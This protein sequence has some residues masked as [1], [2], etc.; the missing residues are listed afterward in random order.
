MQHYPIYMLGFLQVTRAQAKIFPQEI[1]NLFP[2]NKTL[3]VY[4]RPGGDE[5]EKYLRVKFLRA[6]PYRSVRFGYKRMIK[7]ELDA[8]PLKACIYEWGDDGM[9]ELLFDALLYIHQELRKKHELKHKPIDYKFQHLKSDVVPE[10]Q[11]H[12]Y[13]TGLVTHIPTGRLMAKSKL[14]DSYIKNEIL[15]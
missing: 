5:E 9:E 14:S 4:H 1:E 10:E 7:I 13:A 12:N 11:R 8:E 6:N 2:E 3:H 15:R